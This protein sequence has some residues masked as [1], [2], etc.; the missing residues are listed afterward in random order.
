MK[1]HRLIFY[2][3]FVVYHLAIFLFT[4]QV[5]S[6]KENFQYLIKMQSNI[7]L[8]KYGSFLGFLLVLVDFGWTFFSNR[9]ADAE[10]SKM[11]QDMNVLKA[12]LFD[13]QESGKQEK[14]SVKSQDP[15]A[16]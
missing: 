16:S 7:H 3:I 4:L 6:Q 8:F 12:K 14:P 15:D 1:K 10:K 13:V 5:D 9:T 2:L 11:Q